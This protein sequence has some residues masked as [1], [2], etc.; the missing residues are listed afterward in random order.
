MSQVL[1]LMTHSK[2]IKSCINTFTQ[3]THNLS[4]R[5]LRIL[6]KE[7]EAME[8]EQEDLVSIEMYLILI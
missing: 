8:I 1:V 2:L 5:L 6:P 7:L 4:K 3:F